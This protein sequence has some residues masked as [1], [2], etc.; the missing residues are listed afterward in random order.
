MRFLVGAGE[1]RN[2]R[3]ALQALARVGTEVSLEAFPSLLV[4]RAL[5]AS[6]S[7][8]LRVE[9]QGGLFFKTCETPRNRGLRRGGGG[10]GQ[11]LVSTTPIFLS[12]SPCLPTQPAARP[13]PSPPPSARGL[14]GSPPRHAPPKGCIFGGQPATLAARED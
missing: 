3:G 5:N 6:R 13:C 12:L 4:L 14:P 7:A 8:F 9:L 10:R 11:G 1:L 2:W